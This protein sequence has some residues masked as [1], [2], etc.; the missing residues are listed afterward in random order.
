LYEQERREKIS[1][2][3]LS[4]PFY[5]RFIIPK[6]LMQKSRYRVS[7]GLVKVIG[8]D[9]KGYVCVAADG[10]TRVMQRW[11]LFPVQNMSDYELEPTLGTKEGV[12][13]QIVRKV[14][15]GKY[16]VRWTRPDG[17][18]DEEVTTVNNIRG[19]SGGK[20]MLEDF[21]KAHPEKGKGKKKKKR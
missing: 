2:Y 8:R 6:T 3:E 7:K 19:Q 17:K 18:I 9:G 15:D 12:I 13:E 1:D 11:R 21:D 10:S 14:K 4:P 16:L 20:E 5:A